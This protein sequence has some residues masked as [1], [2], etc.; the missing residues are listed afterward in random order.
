MSK[1]QYSEKSRKSIH[2]QKCVDSIYEFV[3]LMLRMNEAKRICHDEHVLDK[4]EAILGQL[5]F[6]FK[7][8]KGIHKLMEY[9]T[10]DELVGIFV[11]ALEYSYD[12]ISSVFQV[13]SGNKL[14]KKEKSKVLN[15]GKWI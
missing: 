14:T 4:L 11:A 1:H 6:L 13:L 10:D 7:H 15:R 12:Y 3:R 8:S 2:E 5:N 9:F